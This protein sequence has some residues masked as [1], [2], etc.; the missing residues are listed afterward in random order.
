MP[1]VSHLSSVAAAPQLRSVV[2]QALTAYDTDTDNRLQ[3]ILNVLPAGVVL[4]T[5][6]GMVSEANPVAV[7][8]LG[9]PLLG[10]S[11]L[12]VINRCFAPRSDD[13]L[14]VSLKD[15]RRLKLEISPLTPEPGQLI[16]LTDLTQTRQLQSR[17]AHLQ[18]LSTLG[19]MMA[20]LAHQIR[21]P[22]SSAMLYAENLGSAKLNPA[23]QQ[24]FQQ[25]LLAR[26][27]DLEQQVN[28]MLLFARSGTA[29]AVQPFTLQSLLNEINAGAET[30]LL[31]Q[32][33]QLTISTDCPHVY[34]L[35]NL[36]SIAGA[37]NNLIQNSLQAVC[38]GAHIHI[39]V[40]QLNNDLHFTVTDNGP[41]ISKELQPHIFEPFFSQ[42]Q[43]GSGL[44]LAVVQAVV[45]SHQGTV[46]YAARPDC[47]ACFV[48]TLP[49]HSAHGKAPDADT[50]TNAHKPVQ[51]GGVE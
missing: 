42:R 35:G 12:E 51:T 27:H 31:Q 26:L 39:S 24:Q 40:R 23:S 49:L 41:G 19:K 21:T 38:N 46:H 48:I 28:D 47:G 6:R 4:L 50:R 16:V 36:S 7:S 2:N 30:S 29:Q 44:G 32:Q 25:K 9:Q 37:I 11:W 22:L 13:G 3:H 5:A 15:G 14:E 45:N 8:M 17:L 34:M 1:N 10:H 33:A 18:R 20:T 43:H